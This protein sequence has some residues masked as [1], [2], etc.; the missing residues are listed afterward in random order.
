MNVRILSTEDLERKL[1]KSEEKPESI[2]TGFS[3]AGKTLQLIGKKD[4]L[5]FVRLE[6]LDLTIN[7]FFIDKRFK[8]R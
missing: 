1:A 4:K 3:L 6:D 7:E 2:I 5:V 8:D